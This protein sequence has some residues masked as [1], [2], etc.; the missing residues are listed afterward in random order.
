MASVNTDETSDAASSA[1]R[2]PLRTRLRHMYRPFKQAS[3]VSRGLIFGGL[4]VI[5]VFLLIAFV[6]PLLYRYD[7]TQYRKEV[8]PGEFEKFPALAGPSAEHPFGTTKDGFDVLARV[9]DAASL[10]FLVMAI[11]VSIAMGLGVT[12]GLYSGY[13]GGKLDRVLVTCM[14]AIYAF[15]SLVLAIIVGFVLRTVMTPGVFPAAAAVAVVYIPQYYR[16]VRN[17]T[18]SVK[19]E[20]FVEAAQS[21]GAKKSTILGRYVFFN[22]VQ[23]VPVILTLHAADS[24]LV[25]ASLGF[26]G[27]G[28][29]YPTAEWGLDI[30]QAVNDVSAG[31][32][33]TAF[34]PGA[35]I[36]L[37][38]TALTLVGEGVNDVVNPLLRA[39]GRAGRKIRAIPRSRRKNGGESSVHSVTD[40]ETSDGR[41]LAARIRDLR[42]GYRTPDGPLWAV[43]GVDLEL[44][45]GEVV[46]LVGESGSGKS[47][48]GRAMLRLMPPG[49]VVTG[50]VE[51]DDRDIVTSSESTVRRMRGEAVP[52]MFQE[53]VTR[54]NPLMRISDTFVEMIR[55]DQR[56]PPR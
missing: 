6:A 35:A 36:V 49:G 7:G 21:F 13:R 38:V 24:I 48:M 30:S 11:A 4:S 27:Y 3:R 26:L 20:A 41:E 17:H 34:W 15:P 55:T 28:V 56:K 42:V 14:D 29:P 16:V 10:A 8:A 54:L 40:A 31:I 33:W 5:A 45:A 19:G 22:V 18:F 44:R 32:W 2:T 25:L 52:L 9:I 51:I 1:R 47:S 37:L 12:L 46:G 39:R 43:D 23:T 50:E 53:P